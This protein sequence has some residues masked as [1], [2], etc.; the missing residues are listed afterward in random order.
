M[1]LRVVI[2]S[3][4][5]GKTQRL[6]ELAIHTLADSSVKSSEQGVLA[7]T[8][9]RNAAAELRTRILNVL[10]QSQDP[11][12]RELARGI[13]LGQ[14][15]LY[16]QTIDSLV[17]ELYQQIA[18]LLGVSVYD[19]LIIEEEDQIE[20]A[21][22]LGRHVLSQ[23]RSPIQWRILRGY[24]EQ[25]VKKSA[26]R[27]IPEAFMRREFLRL[28]QEEPLRLLVRKALYEALRTGKLSMLSMEWAKAL[29]IEK[30]EALFVPHLIGAMEVYRQKNGRLFLS[31]VTALVQ[32][33]A[34]HLGP[35][36][37]EH[38]SFYRHLLVDEAQDT[39]PQQWEI[40][41]PLIEE[42]TSRENGE[43]TLIGDPKQSIYAWRGADFRQ[44]MKFYHRASHVE[45]LSH[46]FRSGRSI[47]E[48]NNSLYTNLPEK[49]SSYLAKRKSKSKSESE[50]QANDVKAHAIEALEELYKSE[51]VSQKPAQDTIGQVRVYRLD[52][53]GDKIALRESRRRVLIDILEELRGKGV[54]PE[55]TA[56]L[57]RRNDQIRELIELLPEYPLQVQQVSLGSCPSLQVTF[58]YILGEADAVA[59]TYAVTYQMLP[60][61]QE[62]GARLE[63][64]VSP[65]AKWQV[66]YEVYT[67]WM[68]HGVEHHMPFWK[69][70]LSHLHAFLH[71]HP[72]YGRA[73][74]GRWWEEKARYYAL[75]LPPMQGV[76]PILTI[77]RAKGLA[78]EA[79]ILPFVEWELLSKR[80][81]HAQWRS[82]QRAD[83]PAALA[84]AFFSIEP[85]LSSDSSIPLPIKVSSKSSE[86]MHLYRDYLREYVVESVNLH[87]VATTRARACLYLIAAAPSKGAHAQKGVY[88]W[89][90]FWNSP[91]LSEELWS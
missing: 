72:F 57:V 53:S 9:T 90:G 67:N 47:V 40:L 2:A 60:V 80:W 83:L 22:V 55:E 28:M 12:R 26:R 76:Y 65:L 42:L 85:I 24:L 64:E 14:V 41:R 51:S 56:L 84:E 21:Q 19:D 74:I 73:E 10:S 52:Y 43:V 70:L 44:L 59:S 35:L 88:T 13:I 4:G 15:S 58:H 31:D 78:W 29:S 38:T 18:P 37:S 5:S 39:S 81:T 36:I 62:L 1:S 89:Q 66:F 6:A 11:I 91:E 79:V 16:T 33:T 8:F 49:L 69:L 30:P 63:S 86:M 45:V 68:T 23:M 25:A 82:L 3:A 54:S 46:N 17:R 27:V 50:P 7:I 61:L 75:E 77:H 71:A 34:R 87:Y 32:L 20:V 48:W